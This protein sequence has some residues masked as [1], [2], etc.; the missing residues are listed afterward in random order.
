[1]GVRGA[2]EIGP[3]RGPFDQFGVESRH[4][5]PLECETGSI[6]DYHR[7]WQAGIDESG[8]DGPAPGCKDSEAPP[9][10]HD[11]NLSERMRFGGGWGSLHSE[12]IHGG[13]QH[14]V[15]FRHRIILTEAMWIS[16][17]SPR[18]K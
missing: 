10:R 13:L 17:N 18:A 5:G 7:D 16:R 15:P 11:G 1:M 6:R 3:V 2:V 12:T 14:V 8:Q 4:L 9:L